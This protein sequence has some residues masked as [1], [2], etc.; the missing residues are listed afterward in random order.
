VKTALVTSQT[1]AAISPGPRTIDAA[2][3][4]IATSLV[5]LSPSRPPH[6]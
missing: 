2:L 3:M 4:A 5:G 6:P 1:M